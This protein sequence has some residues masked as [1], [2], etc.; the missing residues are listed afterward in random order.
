MVENY[1]TGKQTVLVPHLE[2]V[3][4]PAGLTDF[5]AEQAMARLPHLH[6]GLPHDTDTNEHVSPR[7]KI[8]LF[9]SE[10][11]ARANRWSDADH[12]FVVQALRDS[13]MNGIEYIEVEQAKRQPPWAKYDE[14]DEETIIGLA[15][16]TGQIETVLF[17]ERENQ[18]RPGVIEELESL[19]EPAETG[20]ITVTA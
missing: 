18:N 13:T 4:D 10:Y 6:T 2:A 20:E 8:R 14:Q 11:A 17:Y 16:A 5:E 1:A 12:E 3:F 7:F 9:D 15:E 19:L